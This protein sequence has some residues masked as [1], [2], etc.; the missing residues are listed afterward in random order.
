VALRMDGRA[1]TA[2]KKLLDDFKAVTPD[3]AV[4]DAPPVP[5]A[6]ADAAPDKKDA[7]K[8]V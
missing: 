5:P 6:A 1:M 7:K 8:P 3:P 4:N 2:A